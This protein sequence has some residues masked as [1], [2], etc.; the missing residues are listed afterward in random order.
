MCFEPFDYLDDSLPERFADDDL[1]RSIPP[2]ISTRCRAGVNMKTH[3]RYSGLL[4]INRAPIIS[5][6]CILMLSATVASAQ[7]FAPT[8]SMEFAQGP[9]AT[10]LLNGKVLLSGI[11]GPYLPSGGS[12]ELYDPATGTFSSTGSMITPRYFH[13]AT[14][15]QDGTVLVAGG[16]DNSENYLTT[17]EIYDPSSG[18]FHATGSMTGP[19][20]GATATLLADGQVLIASGGT[21]NA[22]ELYDPTTGTFNLTGLMNVNRAGHVASILANGEV[23]LAG[24]AGAYDPPYLLS[25]ELYNPSTGVFTLTGSMTTWH[26][27]GTATLLFDGRVLVVGGITVSTD[28]YDPVTGTFSSGG[29]PV[30]SYAYFSSTLLANGQVLIAGGLTGSADHGPGPTA[31]ANLF[32]PSSGTITPTGSLLDPAEPAGATLLNNGLVLVR[33]PA[34]SV[35]CIAI[36]RPRCRS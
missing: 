35:N 14:L 33:V 19:R 3:F 30:S 25:A 7:T 13:T 11:P 29:N 32:D 5:A 31:A 20:E 12:A 24:G 28:I 26:D 21:T 6:I 4:A 18:A 17:A 15:L 27:G 10:L 1:T 36:A 22:A 8:G 9:V 16:F 23:L 34:S 2:E